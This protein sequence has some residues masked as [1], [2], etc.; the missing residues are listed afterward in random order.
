MYF[1]SS[2][3]DIWMNAFEH[4]VYISNIEKQCIY[5]VYLI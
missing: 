1:V 2:I 3:V 4:K 5:A